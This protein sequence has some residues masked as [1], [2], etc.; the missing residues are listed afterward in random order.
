[1]TSARCNRYAFHLLSEGMLGIAFICLPGQATSVDN[2]LCA[3]LVKTAAQ[4]TN[5]SQEIALEFLT[6]LTEPSHPTSENA[7]QGPLRLESLSGS[8]RPVTLAHPG[9]LV[10]AFHSAFSKAHK[11]VT[12]EFNREKIRERQETIK[13][14]YSQL[15]NFINLVRES[16][17]ALESPPNPQEGGNAIVILVPQSDGSA[18]PLSIPLEHLKVVSAIGAR[19]GQPRAARMTMVTGSQRWQ[20]RFLGVGETVSTDVSGLPHPIKTSLWEIRFILHDKDSYHRATFAINPDGS[21]TLRS[22]GG[23]LDGHTKASQDVNNFT[24]EFRSYRIKGIAP[25]ARTSS[26]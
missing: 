10:E 25:S 23:A 16:G 9:R 3:P 20:V 13:E 8:G 5:L 18:H 24:N 2:D 7:I 19:G 4:K 17:W 6:G 12:R 11:G 1:M 14:V 15:G 26:P 22:Y 21:I